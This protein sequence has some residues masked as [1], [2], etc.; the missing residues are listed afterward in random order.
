MSDLPVFTRASKVIDQA[1]EDLCMVED[2]HTRAALLLAAAEACDVAVLS[3]GAADPRTALELTEAASNCRFAAGTEKR[4]FE[5]TGVY[6][7]EAIQLWA[8]LAGTSDRQVRSGLYLGLA[9]RVDFDFSR[10]LLEH[11]AASE[12]SAVAA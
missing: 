6:D 11:L 10:H 2:A 5:V 4:M 7:R 8:Q 3:L 1:L 12:R 9:R